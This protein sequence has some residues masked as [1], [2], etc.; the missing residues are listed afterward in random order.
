MAVNS[1]EELLLK[2][3][4]GYR[5]GQKHDV[6]TLLEK[7]IELSISFGKLSANEQVLIRTFENARSRGLIAARKKE[8]LVSA[9][10]MAH[11]WTLLDTDLLSQEGRLL[12]LSS[13]EQ[14]VAFLDCRRGNFEQARQRI[15]AS[16]F[17]DQELE[18]HYGYNHL[19]MHRVQQAH[20]LARIDSYDHQVQRAMG[21]TI[22]ILSYLDGKTDSLS[23][24]SVWGYDRIRYQSHSAIAMM[25]LQVSSE[26]ALIMAG[27]SHQD[28]K[29]LFTYSFEELTF[30]DNQQCCYSCVYDWLLTK[31]AYSQGDFNAF[32]SRSAILISQ[33]YIGMDLL[34][35]STFIDIIN[36]CNQLGTLTASRLKWEI[37]TDVMRSPK[38][39]HPKFLPF[40]KSHE[41]LEP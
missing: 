14:G 37:I 35:Q 19:I 12:Y 11:A 9:K 21:I 1:C 5:Q 27:I 28:A 29:E 23:L 10:Y 17:I 26:I 31:K 6:L 20:N 39:V 2:N 24:P 8:L 33:R 34:F 18:D 36:V 32:L 4:I 41:F 25:F 13:M 15:I 7:P 3:L 40:F 38:S 16:L 30:S 22:E